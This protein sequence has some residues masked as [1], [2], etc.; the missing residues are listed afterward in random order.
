MDAD[1]CLGDL[2][3]G[4]YEAGIPYA[5]Y[6]DDIIFFSRTPEEQAARLAEIRALLDL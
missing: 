2:D 1:L 3:R 6:S 4:F 5:R